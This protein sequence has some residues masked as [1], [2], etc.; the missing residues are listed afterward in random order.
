MPPTILYGDPEHDSLRMTIP[1]VLLT[2]LG[3]GFIILWNGLEWLFGGT[4]QQWVLISACGALPLG[5]VLTKAADIALKRVWR[6][7]R[8]IVLADE[9]LTFQQPKLPDVVLANPPSLRVG[10]WF[11]EFEAYPRIGRERQIQNGWFCAA[12]QV[13]GENGRLIAQ[14][15]ITP[16]QMAQ[17]HQIAAWQRLQMMELYQLDLSMRVRQFMAPNGR[18]P[19]PPALITGDNGRYW[20]AEK[21]RWEE[22]LELTFEDFVVLVQWLIKATKP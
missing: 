16:K 14:T 19:I 5:L 10:R 22:G 12:V 1:L 15:Y 3:L 4:A 6:S 13:E 8:Q 21:R 17:L 18:P 7:G 2:A 11:Y 20:L 9:S